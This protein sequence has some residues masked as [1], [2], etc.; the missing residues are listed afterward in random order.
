MIIGIDFWAKIEASFETSYLEFC[1][2]F[3][4]MDG[5]YFLHTWY[6]VCAFQETKYKLHIQIIIQRSK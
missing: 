1:C 6:I 4:G 5:Y 3:Y 2:S